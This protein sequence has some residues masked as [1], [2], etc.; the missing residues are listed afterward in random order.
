MR[1]QYYGGCGLVFPHKTYC[2]VQK[3]RLARKA[4]LH[5]EQPYET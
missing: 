5:Y 4:D 1:V 2:A 3:A